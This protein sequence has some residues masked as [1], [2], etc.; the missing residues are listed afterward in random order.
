MHWN[1]MNDCEFLAIKILK[2]IFRRGDQTIQTFCKIC[3]PQKLG[4]PALICKNNNILQNVLL[5]HAE[6]IEI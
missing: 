3:S 4:S 2:Y 5:N 6:Y 1:L